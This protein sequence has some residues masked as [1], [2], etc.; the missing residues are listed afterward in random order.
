[1]KSDEFIYE[2]VK[3][4]ELFAV[5][6]YKDSIFKGEIVERKRH[7]RGVI[8]YHNGRL[9]EGEWVNDKRHGRGYE[10]FTNGN[11]Y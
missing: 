2:E 6:H 3:E 11:T 4:S 1:M 7:G 9:Y 10:L 8:I 5:K